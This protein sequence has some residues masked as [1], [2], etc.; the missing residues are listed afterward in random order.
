VYAQEGWI[1]TTDPAYLVHKFA[2]GTAAETTGFARRATAPRAVDAKW[3]YVMDISLGVIM[4]YPLD[5][6]PP[7]IGPSAP[8]AVELDASHPDY[9]FFTEGSRLH[10]WVKPHR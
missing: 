10:R 8:L 9:L 3:L 1:F 5:G 7:P 4:L 6:G 2:A